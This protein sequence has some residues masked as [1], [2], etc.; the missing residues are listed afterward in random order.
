MSNP[1]VSAVISGIGI[2]AIGWGMLT[3]GED[4]STALLT[5]QWVLLAG[6]II[7]LIG[8]L[9]RMGGR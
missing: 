2:I 8:S 5:L 1:R 7:G 3:N 6:C 9:I 4:A